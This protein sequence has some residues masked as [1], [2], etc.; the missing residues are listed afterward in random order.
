MNTIA[1]KASDRLGLENLN[2]S[3]LIL[4]RI[5]LCQSMTRERSETSPK[6]IEGLEEG[7]FFNSLTGEKYGKEIRIIP[8]HFV[9]SR[10]LF[11][12]RGTGGGFRC[13][14]RNG[15]DGGH[16]SKTCETCL[17][18]KWR[19]KD[20]PECTEFK[21]LIGLL[22]PKLERVV[23]SFH[24]SA[25]SVANDWL[26][27]MSNL[28]DAEDK[29]IF[30]HEYRIQSILGGTSPQTYMTYSVQSAGTTVSEEEELARRIHGTVYQRT[31]ALEAAPETDETEVPF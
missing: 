1:I 21:S 2:Q 7:D 26:T 30:H 25:I 11:N 22:K 17:F 10:I 12:E 27:R 13:S 5:K 3:D 9:R 20:P 28:M 24:G 31:L 14:S 8:V 4:P 29:P 15:I 19:E 16:Y 18:S 6:H 23:L